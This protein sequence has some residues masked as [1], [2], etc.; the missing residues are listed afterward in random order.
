MEIRTLADVAQVI[1]KA[2]KTNQALP[3]V[4]KQTYHC[5]LGNIIKPERK[6]LMDEILNHYEPPFIPKAKDVD[7]WE[8]VCFKW[9]PLL[10]NENRYIVWDRCSG[11]GWKSVII[12]FQKRTGQQICVRTAQRRFNEGCLIIYSKVKS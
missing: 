11:M 4:F 5:P 10:E 9:L 6:E 2:C 8:L 1:R 7:E 12:S 3:T